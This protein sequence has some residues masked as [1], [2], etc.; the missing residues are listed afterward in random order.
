[1]S[2]KAKRGRPARAD[3]AATER[4]EVRAT[5]L[6]R[7]AWEHAAAQ[8]GISLSEWIRRSLEHV[9]KVGM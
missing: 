1:V 2:P 8:A 5:R 6:E 3:S 4:V 9:R 7:A